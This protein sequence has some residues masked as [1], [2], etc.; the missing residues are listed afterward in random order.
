MFGCVKKIMANVL[1]SSLH[2]NDE[3]NHV[4]GPYDCPRLSKVELRKAQ[5]VAHKMEFYTKNRNNYIVEN[6][7]DR[8]FAM[9]D[10]NWSY[11][12][13]NEFVKL[14]LRILKTQSDDIRYLRAFSSTFSGYNLYHLADGCGLTASDLELN[15]HT[16]D[17]IY[18]KISEFNSVFVK[19]H[20]ELVGG[21]PSRFVFNPPRKLGELGHVVNEVLVNS[22]TNSYQERLNIMYE[23]G[24]DAYV[25]AIH[26]QN[27][28]VRVLEIGGGYGAIA[29]WFNNAYPDCHYT[30]LDLPESLLFSGIYL[31]ICIPNVRTS[32]GLEPLVKGIRFIPNYMAELLH[33]PFDLIINTLSMSEMSRY[34]VERYAELMRT[35]W[36]KIS[37]IFFEQ[38]QDNRHM[39]L[40]CAQEILAPFF[41]YHVP[42]NPNGI[43]YRNGAPNAWSHSPISLQPHVRKKIDLYDVKLI[44]DIG[45]Y[46]LVQ[47]DTRF[48]ALH[49][50]LGEV[51]VITLEFKDDSNKVLTGSS[52]EE[53]QRKLPR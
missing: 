10:A 11:D 32:F 26:R 24:I 37:G 7:V 39:G 22:D 40:Q 27:R 28:P 30:I 47:Q 19:D 12:A 34:Q 43:G 4:I 49:K 35:H 53:V 6:E 48:W 50:S 51:D 2:V 44:Q 25:D 36:I 33:E 46:N 41:P 38:N 45:E 42:L 52:A 13:P 15:R 23:T 5:Y 21:I 14:F 31:S 18:G 3:K 9:P 17:M 29:Y 16:F 8:R 1:G 20:Q